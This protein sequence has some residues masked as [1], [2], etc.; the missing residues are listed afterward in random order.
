MRIRK[1]WWNDTGTKQLLFGSTMQGPAQ[2]QIFLYASRKYG[3]CHLGVI[4][5]PVMIL[6]WFFFLNYDLLNLTLSSLCQK[7]TAYIRKAYSSKSL[8]TGICFSHQYS[9][10]HTNACFLIFQ[11]IYLFTSELLINIT[12]YLFV[13]AWHSQHSL[14]E[15]G[16]LQNPYY[17]YCSSSCS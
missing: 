5:F 13:V 17:Y 15:K 2:W 9:S 10:P 1:Q 4:P 8:I 11:F 3:C 6:S 16:I 14:G 12:S 7:L